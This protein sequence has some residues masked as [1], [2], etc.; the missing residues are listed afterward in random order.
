[1]ISDDPAPAPLYHGGA[2]GEALNHIPLALPSPAHEIQAA[3][4]WMHVPAHA[5][6][7][8]FPRASTFGRVYKRLYSSWNSRN[9]HIDNCSQCEINKAN[10][11]MEI[12]ADSN[13]SSQC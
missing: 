6:S 8:T 9:V 5:F 3:S 7:G 11:A 13:Y 2:P 4:A 1:M 10:R 12:V